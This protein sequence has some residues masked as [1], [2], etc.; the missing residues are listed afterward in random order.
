MYLLTGNLDK[1]RSFTEESICCME[2]WLALSPAAPGIQ[3]WLFRQTQRMA[4]I[5]DHDDDNLH[6][7]CN[8]IAIATL[9]RLKSAQE[10]H[11]REML[12]LVHS[13]RGHADD[14]MLRGQ[15][16]RARRILEGDLR[17]L[18]SVP[19]AETAFPAHTLGEALA[20][21]RMGQWSGELTLSPDHPQWAKL[22]ASLLETIAAELL[23][24]RI[25]WLPSIVRPS[26]LIPE[27]LSAEAWT[28]RVIS[29]AQSDARS[30]RLD[31]TRVA[32]VCWEMTHYGT[33]SWF[34]KAGKLGE[35]Q[36]GIDR[37]L[38]L[39][40]RLTESYPD[41]GAVYMF[42]SEICRLR[43]KVAYRVDDEP[44]VEWEQK[45]FEAALHAA[46]LEPEND[47]AL[48]IVKTAASDCAGWRQSSG[49]RRPASPLPGR[50]ET[51]ALRAEPTVPGRQPRNNGR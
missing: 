39:A 2:A 36:Q 7:R 18:R 11:A 43:L 5:I 20:L 29:A 4:A 19:A 10:E 23:A 41:Q 15:W 46:T 37:W 48:S 27:N 33:L 25:G 44:V 38:A 8:S 3:G 14:L 35:A 51:A 9:E 16:D 24:R 42:L 30:L 13:H 17:L 31:H 45:A 1:A 49:G 22:D 28:D 50:S 6:E 47:E 26:W 40:R 34:R 12:L 21:A 32:G